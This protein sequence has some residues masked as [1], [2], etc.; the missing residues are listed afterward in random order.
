MQKKIEQKIFI[1]KCLFQRRTNLET[2][3]R[4]GKYAYREYKLED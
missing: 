1:F 4:D 3:Q 2:K